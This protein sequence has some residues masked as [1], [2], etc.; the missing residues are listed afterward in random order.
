VVVAEVTKTVWEVWG[1]GSIRVENVYV[2]APTG[3]NQVPC[4]AAFKEADEAYPA[5]EEINT[6]PGP[7]TGCP[8]VQLK[9]N[10]ETLWIL[11]PDVED[12][13]NEEEEEGDAEV[14]DE[15]EEDDDDDDDDD[16]EEDEE[17]EEVEP[18]EPVVT[19]AG[20]AVVPEVNL[21][22]VDPVEAAGQLEVT[23]KTVETAATSR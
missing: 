4:P 1:R 11:E 8:L 5:V 19:G 20:T 21:T 13:D 7:L 16:E 6:V 2:P 14:E 17:D 15:E 23:L 9:T 10:R 12:D 3:L 18:V 22:P